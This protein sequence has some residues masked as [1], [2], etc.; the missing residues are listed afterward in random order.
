LSY[1]EAGDSL[2]AAQPGLVHLPW[3]SQYLASK[4]TEA[5]ASYRKALQLSPDPIERTMAGLALGGKNLEHDMAPAAAEFKIALRLNPRNAYAHLQLGKLASRANDFATASL[6]L[7]EAVRL[8]PDLAKPN[9]NWAGCISI[10]RCWS[11][12]R[13]PCALP[14]VYNRK[15]YRPCIGW[16]RCC[17]P[18][19]SRRRP[20][21]TLSKCGNCRNRRTASRCKRCKRRRKDE[22]VGRRTSG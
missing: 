18:A 15:M 20:R 1:L 2:G 22:C 17:K 6:H 11:K 7:R 10:R 9:R 4:Y 19:A 16:R 12:L 13:G 8:Q 3:Q 5:I 14:F 21:P